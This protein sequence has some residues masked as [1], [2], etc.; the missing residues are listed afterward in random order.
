MHTDCIPDHWF[1]SQCGLHSLWESPGYE[2][3]SHWS[4]SRKHPP[5]TRQR[6]DMSMIQISLPSCEA[7]TTSDGLHF[8]KKD[9]F[10]HPQSNGKEADVRGWA[11]LCYSFGHPVGCC[12][13]TRPSWGHHQGCLTSVLNPRVNIVRDFWIQRS[14]EI[15]QTW[16]TLVAER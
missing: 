16:Y 6:T 14:K 13:K 10:T 4:L 11:N 12:R 7:V 2:C 9:W 15:F 3:I 5:L 8:F 1:L